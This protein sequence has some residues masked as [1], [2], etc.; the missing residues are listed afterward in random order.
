MKIRE[1]D[2]AVTIE[3][4]G[5][6]RD[7]DPDFLKL[8][9]RIAW[10]TAYAATINA[11]VP[12]TYIALTVESSPDVDRSG[13][14]EREDVRDNLDR[15]EKVDETCDPVHRDHRQPRDLWREHRAGRGKRYPAV[16]EH[17]H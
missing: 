13:E 7:R 6:L 9:V 14:D 8:G 12:Y 3:L 10:E 4:C 15:H 16:L 1:L 11:G 17:H 5:E 2:H